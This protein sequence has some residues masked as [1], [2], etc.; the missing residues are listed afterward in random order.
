MTAR[1]DRPLAPGQECIVLGWQTRHEGRKHFTGTALYDAD[2][3]LV[4]C[5]EQIWI[6]VKAR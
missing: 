6:E 4:G 5:A 3:H 1:I 2:A